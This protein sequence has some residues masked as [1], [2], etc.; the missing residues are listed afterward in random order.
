M[1]VIIL[2]KKDTAFAQ[3]ILSGEWYDF[4]DTRVSKMSPD[5]IKVYISKTSCIVLY[6]NI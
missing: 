6:T 4:D 2:L 5:N 1:C 3:N